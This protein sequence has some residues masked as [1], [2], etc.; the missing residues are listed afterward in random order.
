MIKTV[1]EKKFKKSLRAYFTQKKALNF[2]SRMTFLCETKT[3]DSMWTRV[4]RVLREQ[5]DCK[6]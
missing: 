2:V 5:N 4:L 1:Q 6:L 3:C